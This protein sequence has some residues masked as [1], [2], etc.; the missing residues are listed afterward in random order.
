MKRVSIL[1]ISLVILS[2]GQLH[3]Q[4]TDR[5]IQK[6]NESYKK[7][8]YP[9]AEAAYNEV[10]NEDPA[11]NTAKYNKAAALYRQTKHDESIK[12]LD[13]LAFKTEAT[14]LR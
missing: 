4:D 6:G 8:E 10:L 5:I 7:K 2:G 13:D 9:M 12:V 14:E 1:I 3:A 11:N